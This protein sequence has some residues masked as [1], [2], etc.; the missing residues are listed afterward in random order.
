MDLD[1]NLYLDLDRD[2]I[3]D[4]NLDLD[5]TMNKNLELNLD[6]WIWIGIGFCSAHTPDLAFWIVAFWSFL[7]LSRI[8]GFGSGEEGAMLGWRRER[9]RQEMTR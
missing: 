5:L 8:L 2:L 7:Y 3:M 1:L 6:R 4:L 9:W